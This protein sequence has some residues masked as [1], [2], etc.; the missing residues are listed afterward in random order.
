MGWIERLQTKWKVKNG[1]QVLVILVVF[2]CTGF[3]VLFLKRP[4]LEYWFPSGDKP[5]WASILYWVLIFPVYNIFLL[6][7]GLVFGQFQ[8]FWEFEKR[9]FNRIKSIFK[10]KNSTL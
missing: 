3:T 9:F 2:A 5:T 8:F 1:L 10:N 6:L 4:L 7:Y